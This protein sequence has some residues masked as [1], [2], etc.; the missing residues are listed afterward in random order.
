MR[1]IDD[2]NSCSNIVLC[3]F[4]HVIYWIFKGFPCKKLLIYLISS[5]SLCD[6]VFRHKKKS[7]APLSTQVLTQNT[8]NLSNHLSTHVFPGFVKCKRGSRPFVS[9]KNG[10]SQDYFEKDHGAKCYK[11]NLRA[12]FKFRN[13]FRGGHVIISRGCAGLSATENGFT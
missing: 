4:S 3:I 6:N 2:R 11:K 12:N 1:S 10:Y 9:V 8:H 7:I 5:A 13:S